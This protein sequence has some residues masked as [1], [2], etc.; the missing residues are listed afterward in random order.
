MTSKAR[1][2]SE[3][4]VH[5]REGAA[6]EFVDERLE[7]APATVEAIAS[8]VTELLRPPAVGGLI[9]ATDVARR[10]GVSRSWVYAN[11][12]ELGAVR[13]GH[14]AKARLRFD[15]DRIAERL[16]SRSASERSQRPESPATK[17]RTRRRN[18]S[19]PGQRSELLPIK[20]VK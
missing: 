19:Q 7:L 3:V 5:D 11:A 13:L 6:V 14:G 1:R 12:T 10:Y 20:E 17:P 8:R 2:H 16:T 4:G 18:K 9:D 15:P